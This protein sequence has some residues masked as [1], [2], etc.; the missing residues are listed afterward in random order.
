M[1]FAPISPEPQRRLAHVRLAPRLGVF[2]GAAGVFLTWAAA[3]GAQSTHGPA[4]G[5]IDRPALVVADVRM[6]QA[7]AEYEL[8]RTR[9]HARARAHALV[10]D[11]RRSHGSPSPDDAP[12]PQADHAHPRPHP[13]PVPPKDTSANATILGKS[14]SAS[15]RRHLVPFLPRANAANRRGFVRVVNVANESGEVLVAA[16]D[17]GGRKFGP[18]ALSIGARQA[19]RLSA[20]DLQDGNAAKGLPAGFGAPSEGDWR[21]SL[22]SSLDIR[23]AALAQ[24]EDAAFATTHERLRRVDGER[25][26]VMRRHADTARH[27]SWLRLI[28]PNREPATVTIRGAPV[29]E[30]RVQV[31]PDGA[32]NVTVEA[33]EDGVSGVED[34]RGGSWELAVRS[35]RPIRALHLLA[36]ADGRLTNLSAP[37]RAPTREGDRTIHRVPFFPAAGAAAQGLLRVAN[38]SAA[39]ATVEIHASDD[40]GRRAGPILLEVAAGDLLHLTAEDLEQGNAGKGVSGALG[41]GEGAWRLRLHA[42]DAAAAAGAGPPRM[43]VQAY[44]RMADGFLSNLNAL[45]PRI[46]EVA[47]VAYFAPANGPAQGGRLRLVNWGDADVEATVR[48]VDA[49]G[50]PSAGAMRATVPAN[51]ARTVTA[52][53][54]ESGGAG[55]VGALGN[56]AGAW[57]LEVQ[58]E[59]PLDVMGLLVGPDGRVA[60]LSTFSVP[61]DTSA[62]GIFAEH[63]AAIVEAKCARC[64]VVGGAAAHTR[65]VFE[66]GGGASALNRNLQAFADFLAQVADGANVVLQRIQGVGHGGGAQVAAGT[67]DHALMAQF[68]ARLGEEPADAAVSVATLFDGVRLEPPRATLRRAALVFAGRAPTPTEYAAVDGDA[69]ALRNTLRALMTGAGFH[70]FLLRASNDRLLTDRELARFSVIGNDGFFVDYDNEYVRLREAGGRAVWDWHHAVQYGAGRAPLELIAHVV[71]NDL[72]YTEILTANYVMANPAVA[73]VYGASSAFDDLGDAHEFQ[74]AA[75]TRYHHRGPG[76]LAVFEPDVGL[77]VLSPG[78]LATDFP[79]VGLLN[80]KAFL[81]RY[82]STATNRNRARARWTYYHFLGVDVERSASRTTDPVALADRDNPTLRNPA[83]TV[84]HAALDPV[85]GAF[86][87]YGD[88]GYYRDQWGGVDAL[89]HFYKNGAESA[90]PIRAQGA[91]GPGPAWTL[92]LPA[93]QTTLGVTYTNDFYDEETGADGTVFLDRLRVLDETGREVAH[94]EFETATPVAP[95]GPCGAPEA[96]HHLRLWNGG[97]ECAIHI[98]L[99][100][101]TAGAHRLEISAWAT[102]HE[103]YGDDGY[104]KLS[105][106]AD[107]YRKGDT[108]YR[109]M[110]PPGFDARALPDANRSLRW[111]ARRIAADARFAPAT[112][113]FWWPAVMGGEVAEPPLGEDGA[114]FRGRLLAATAQHAEVARLAEGFRRGFGGGAAHNLKD[115][116]VELALSPWFRANAAAGELDPL[117]QVALRDA[118]AKRLLTPEELSR[119]TAAL[120][121]FEWGRWHHPARK[122]HR[123]RSAAL[124]DEDGYRLLYGGIDSDGVTT[125]TRRMTSVMAGVAKSHAAHASCPVV[126]REFYLLPK[127][128]RRLFSRIGVAVSPHF[129]LAGDFALDTANKTYSVRGHLTAGAKTAFLKFPNDFADANGDRNVRLDRLVVLDA[130]GRRAHTTELETLPAQNDC[131]FPV[132]DHYALHCRGWLKVPFAVDA[133]GVYAVEVRARADVHGDEAPQLQ[134][135]VES[136]SGVTPTGEGAIKRQLAHLHERLLGLPAAAAAA[137][138]DAAYPLFLAIW[139]RKRATGDTGF[140]DAAC[141]WDSDMRFLDG[142]LPDALGERSGD[143]GPYKHWRWP[144]VDAFW[145]ARDTS[146]PH[147]AA[148]AWVAVLAYLMMDYRYLH[149]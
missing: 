52:A 92:G 26:L 22:T 48:G 87:N 125:R 82:P 101:Q 40:T 143:Y 81:Q 65:L 17:D 84:C 139:Q 75:I 115:L 41:A 90:L 3:A 2:G 61:V 49:S 68:L 38:R 129:E 64:H 28:N 27:T 16:T 76:Y 78:P 19:V 83:C 137:E 12:V 10:R 99:S 113:R 21:L 127:A 24:V 30:L 39:A 118:G 94:Y 60:N 95:W 34:T 43:E 5:A 44:A 36:N 73:A 31:P 47:E 23:V 53:Q 110:R 134:V 4:H 123:Q 126:L 114:N 112:V 50:A 25:R 147:Y 15:P 18:V 102:R 46:G 105:L 35:D 67:E 29:R 103:L 119:K 79:L 96:D 32:R 133:A 9:A 146:D 33:L 42:A 86:Q 132:A 85:A 74:P 120:T 13:D 131:N 56:G 91:A 66:P 11:N 37:P 20:Q 135:V 45:A 100:I 144:L 8:Q 72:P 138:A 1:T 142:F 59:R 107:P 88:S 108:W 69:D 148:R 6:A 14:Q 98:P 57:R 63:I 71:E 89:D 122:P 106:V 54:L 55:L 116:L 145:R 104:A 124:V 149:L 121:G 136:A 141:H 7:R 109:D 140:W 117:R 58:A 130:S 80:T 93:G 111:L 70:E 97:F 51:G 77:R 62:A 128:E